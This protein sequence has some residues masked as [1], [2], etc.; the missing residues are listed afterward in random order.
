MSFQ[1]LTSRKAKSY[2]ELIGWNVPEPSMFAGVAS[3]SSLPIS[4]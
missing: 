1:P 2:A 3:L 4:V